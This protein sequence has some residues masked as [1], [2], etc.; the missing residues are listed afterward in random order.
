[1]KTLG[2][3]KLELMAGGVHIA[4]TDRK[5]E[6]IQ[7]GLSEPDGEITF[8]L[9]EDFFVRTFAAPEVPDRPRLTVREERVWLIAGKQ[10]QEV[11]VIAP[12]RFLTTHNI[13]DVHLDGYCL[14]LFLHKVDETGDLNMK[15]A[16]VLA[17][18]R[19]AFEEGVADLIQLNMEYCEAEDRGVNQLV[20]LIQSIKKNFRTFVGLRG[21]PPENL[22]VIDLVYAAGAELLVFPLE[23]A[24]S[25]IQA[26]AEKGLRALEY[27]AGVFSH[28]TV[29]TELGFGSGDL[30]PLHRQITDLA[31]KRIT[32]MMRL[33][34]PGAGEP[35]DFERVRQVVEYL[36][37]QAGRLN[38]NWLYPSHRLVT[39]LDTRFF[40]EPAEKARLTLRPMYQSTLGKSA[41][42]GFTALRRKLRVKNISD[43]YESAGL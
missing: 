37:E 29:S 7:K 5:H 8:A 38:L 6:P 30:E 9:A 39:P 25:T 22:E 26:P 32:P 33:A 23:E 17:V 12:P 14:N 43:S 19:A 34:E 20:Q 21:Y 4:D 41:F 24:S 11:L 35:A 2:Q 10:E 1:M 13:P 28:G 16:D 42:E 3:L 36:A 40:T 31:Q 27:A 15:T 18:I